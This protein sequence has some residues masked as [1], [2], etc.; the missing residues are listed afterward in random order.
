MRQLGLALVL[1]TVF[2]NPRAPVTI[3]AQAERQELTT[4]QIMGAPD[5][6]LTRT[7]TVVIVEPL[8]GPATEKALAS[9]EYGQVRVD[10][11]DGGPEDLSLMPSAFRLDDPNRYKRKF[12]RPLVSPIKVRGE[13]LIDPELKH[14]KSYIIRVAYYEP[15]SPPA[16]MPV[17]SLAEIEAAPAKWDRQRIVYEGTYEHAFEVSSLDRRIWLGFSQA[18]ALVNRPAKQLGKHKVRVTGYLYARPG[19]RYGH[20]GGYTCELVADRI[21]F[22]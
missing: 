5:R 13:F 19:G 7:V 20:L 16:P 3:A 17:R 11:P 8:S 10:I 21:E 15:L 14:R 12:D 4:S 6:Y 18:T 9:L 1:A 22:L 2:G